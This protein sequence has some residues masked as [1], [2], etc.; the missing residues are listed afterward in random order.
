MARWLTRPLPSPHIHLQSLLEVLETSRPT[1]IPSTAVS[2][3]EVEIQLLDSM[4]CVDIL[5]EEITLQLAPFCAW[6][7]RNVDDMLS[8]YI[9]YELEKVG[10]LDDHH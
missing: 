4:P 10:T 5:S 2:S 7:N 9:Q 1:L 6:W 8:Y 3:E